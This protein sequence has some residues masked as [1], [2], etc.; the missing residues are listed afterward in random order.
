MRKTKN[1]TKPGKSRAVYP[2]SFDPVTRGHIDVARRAISLFD[3]VVIAVINNPSKKTCFTVRERVSMLKKAFAR[4]GLDKVK[5]D[6]F[7][8]LLVNY[9]K[10]I[11]A[12]IIVRGLRAVSD[13]EYEFQM[14]LMN[15]KLAPGIETV[16]FMTDA[17][18]AYLS[19]SIVKEVAF[20]GGDVSSAVPLPAAVKLKEKK[21]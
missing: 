5:V 6:S 9:M 7:E 4:E 3:E 13:F 19:S 1:K 11:K 10:N 15:R 18:Y 20:L 17:K 8:G 14:A 21:V 12:G 16:F 2:G